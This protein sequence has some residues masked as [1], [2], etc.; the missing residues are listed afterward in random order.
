MDQ[1]FP[2]LLT[3][4]L[5]SFSSPF[6][7]L[8]I[9]IRLP[10]TSPLTPPLP[11]PSTFL[12][13]PF[14]SPFPLSL[15]PFLPFTPNPARKSEGVLWA[16]PSGVWGWVWCIE[17]V[18]F[19]WKIRH[20]MRI[21][22]VTFMKNYTDY[23]LSLAKHPLKILLEYLLQR[24][25]SIDAAGCK[26]VGWL[27]VCWCWHEWQAVNDKLHRA[28]LLVDI[29]HRCDDALFPAFSES[30]IT[31]GQ[32]HVVDTYLRRDGAGDLQPPGKMSS[33]NNNCLIL[34]WC[35]S[36][37]TRWNDSVWRRCLLC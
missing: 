8:S 34:H 27:V 17:F 31:V 37:I 6:L 13:S 4:T 23:T 7:P 33:N 10:L 36:H 2:I 9:I 11:F 12:P 32:R 25:Y 28:T 29:L 18:H 20:P 15:T 30:L 22:L 24:F 14:P 3:H 21:I 35:K 1:I 5:T 16:P 26:A 19:K